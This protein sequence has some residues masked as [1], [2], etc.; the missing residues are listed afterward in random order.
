MSKLQE[1]C[2]SQTNT[3]SSTT[4]PSEESRSLLRRLGRLVPLTLL[5][6]QLEMTTPENSP[7][8][9]EEVRWGEGGFGARALSSPCT[10]TGPLLKSQGAPFPTLTRGDRGRNSRTR[11]TRK[12]SV[13]GHVGALL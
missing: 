9:I 5:L 1:K 7:S 12:L 3:S 13:L 10:S 6:G 4:T 11:P 2:G 8:H